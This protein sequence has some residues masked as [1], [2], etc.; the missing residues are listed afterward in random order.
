MGTLLAIKPVLDHIIHDVLQEND[1]EPAL[2]K[3][4]KRVMREDRTSRYT[5]KANSVMQM[6]CFNNPRFKVSFWVRLKLQ[7]LRAVF[8][9]P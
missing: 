6:A 4:M 1:E 8:K 9:K 3:E 2:T 7:W 5:E